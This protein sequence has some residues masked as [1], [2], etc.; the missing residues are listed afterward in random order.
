M[1]ATVAA[2][3]DKAGEHR[4]EFRDNYAAILDRKVPKKT[5][6]QDYK[7]SAGERKYTSLPPPC[8]RG[9]YTR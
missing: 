2:V 7:V 8:G 1:V 4:E 3:F 6:A 5:Y 9:A